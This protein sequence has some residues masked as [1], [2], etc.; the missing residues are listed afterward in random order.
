MFKRFEHSMELK[1]AHL[2]SRLYSSDL[3]LHEIEQNASSRDIRIEINLLSRVDD[4]EYKGKDVEQRLVSVESSA[5]DSEELLQPAGTP[6][7][8]ILLLCDSNSSGKINFGKERGTL[9]RALF[10]SCEFC[11]GLATC[12]M[13]YCRQC[14]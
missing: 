10:G 12:P 14:R 11:P 3:R 9:N 8:K 4:L 5:P 1:F 13:W 2:D 6:E 7:T